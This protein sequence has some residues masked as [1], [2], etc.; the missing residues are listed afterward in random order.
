MRHLKEDFDSLV[1]KASLFDGVDRRGFMKKALGTGS[2]AAVM[3][4]AAQS[5][6]KTDTAVLRNRAIWC[7]H[8]TCS[9]SRMV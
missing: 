1:P 2:A 3:P 9:L 8:P 7:W 4:V 5:V 6:I